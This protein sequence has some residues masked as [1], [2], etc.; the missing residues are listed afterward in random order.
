[1]RFSLF[2]IVFFISFVSFADV[3]L[4]RAIYEKSCQT[5]HSPNTAPLMGAPTIHD[6]SAWKSR[7]EQAKEAAK[8]EPNVQTTL[9]FLVSEIK[10]GKGAMV[11]GGMCT[12]S[13]TPDRQ[14]TDDAYKSAIEYMTSAK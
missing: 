12:D 4:G 10:H 13:N 3:N 6:M 8:R 1:M 11:P 14:C 5:C 9:D 7:L 2:L